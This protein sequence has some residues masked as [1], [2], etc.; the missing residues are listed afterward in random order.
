MCYACDLYVFVM[1][2]MCVCVSWLL[3][4]WVLGVIG[5][6]R[7]LWV[8]CVYVMGDMRVLPVCPE[9]IMWAKGYLYLSRF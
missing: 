9:V 4:A 3:C 2:I 1:G 7:M 5:V 6:L 8:L